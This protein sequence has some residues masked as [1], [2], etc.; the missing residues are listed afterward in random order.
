MHGPEQF[1]TR[2]CVNWLETPLLAGIRGIDIL[3]QPSSLEGNHFQWA[4][5][6]TFQSWRQRYVKSIP[7]FD[8][9]IERYA[10]RNPPSQKQIYHRDRRLGAG[11]KKRVYQLSD[12]DSEQ[13]DEIEA[14]GNAAKKTVVRA[15]RRRIESSPARSGAPSERDD[16]E[17]ANSHS[18]EKGKGIDIRMLS[19]DD[20]ADGN[21]SRLVIHFIMF[22]APKVAG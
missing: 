14:E 2:L 9:A 13:E 10:K 22:S 20:E 1:C 3:R 21:T 8:K 5:R 12:D 19:D 15:K 7:K 4:K 6:H 11:S 16:V 17:A 18:I